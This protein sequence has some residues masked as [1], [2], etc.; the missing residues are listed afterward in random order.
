[1]AAKLDYQFIFNSLPN[2]TKKAH[3]KSELFLLIKLMNNYTHNTLKWGWYFT[4]FKVCLTFGVTIALAIQYVCNSPLESNLSSWHSSNLNTI[5]IATTLLALVYCIYQCCK[6]NST[7]I[8]SWIGYI[9]KTSVLIMINSFIFNTLLNI[10]G[11]YI[12]P[13]TKIEIEEIDEKSFIQRSNLW[14][15]LGTFILTRV[16]INSKE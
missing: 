12:Q 9:V 11:V 1:M 5:L 13:K 8:K 7:S 10:H 15:D 2:N 14:K 4:V 3:F 16:I 6:E